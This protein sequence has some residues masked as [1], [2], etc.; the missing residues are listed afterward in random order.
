MEWRCHLLVNFLWKCLVHE[1]GLKEACVRSR[2]N[3]TA[4][5]KISG[6]REFIEL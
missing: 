3:M 2:R 1:K 5:A 6:E 4:V